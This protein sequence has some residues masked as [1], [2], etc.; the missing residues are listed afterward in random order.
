MTSE[1]PP[2]RSA[3]SGRG[4]PEGRP[5]RD[6]NEL[7]LDRTDLLQQANRVARQSG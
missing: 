2:E 6:I 5:I 4:F 1:I 7:L 3:D